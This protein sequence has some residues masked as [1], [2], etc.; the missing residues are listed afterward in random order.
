MPIVEEVRNGVPYGVG[1][2]RVTLSPDLSLKA[3]E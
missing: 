3:Y 1:R 2:A